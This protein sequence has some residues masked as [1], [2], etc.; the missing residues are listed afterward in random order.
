MIKN[1]IFLGLFILLIVTTACSHITKEVSDTQELN[2]E[3]SLNSE[4]DEIDS[5]MKDLDTQEFEDLEQDF[6][7]F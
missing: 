4:L 2:E 3:L 7:S 6:D 1:K 5:I